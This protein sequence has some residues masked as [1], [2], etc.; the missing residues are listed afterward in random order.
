M[1]NEEE[2]D[3]EEMEKGEEEEGDESSKVT[4]ILKITRVVVVVSLAVSVV[5][6][7]VL[8]LSYGWCKL[9]LRCT[10]EYSAAV[11]GP[12]PPLPPPHRGLT[13]HLK[14]LNTCHNE[15]DNKQLRLLPLS[16]RFMGRRENTQGMT[17]ASGGQ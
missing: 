15:Q 12:V 14:A 6:K 9:V 1:K 5:I 3:E 16:I 4:L 2:N 8:G 13:R 10:K 7:V 17:Q 11:K